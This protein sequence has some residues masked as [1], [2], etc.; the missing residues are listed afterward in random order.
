MKRLKF[1]VLT[2]AVGSA[3]AAFGGASSAPAQSGVATLTGE[4]LQSCYS[5]AVVGA[6]VSCHGFAH[7]TGPSS[8]RIRSRCTGEDEGRITWNVSGVA[9]GLYPGTYTETGTAEFSGGVLT[10][11]EAN[12][13]IESAVADVDGRKYAPTGIGTCSQFDNGAFTTFV[14]GV[15]RY[16]AIIKPAGGGSFADEGR[17]SL[18]VRGMTADNPLLAETEA[19]LGYHLES[20]LSDL[21][22]ARALLPDAKEQCKDQGF[23]IFGV[24]ENQGDCVSFVST[25]GKNEPGQ[26]Q[27]G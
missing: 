21:A 3:V 16:D 15:V 5:D 18:S 1:L 24:F 27:K 13:H 4:Q 7:D 11:V 17:A 9:T 8:V 23:L 10:N 12:F 22:F 14:D 19:T 20:F 26:N 2:L 6:E 25:H